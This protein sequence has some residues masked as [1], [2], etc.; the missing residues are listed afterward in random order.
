MHHGAGTDDVLDLKRIAGVVK[1]TGAD[2]IGLQEVDRQE[3]DRHWSSR[4]DFAD[5]AQWLA[6]RLHMHVVYGANLDLDPEQAGDPRRQY[7]T[8][9]L[10]RFPVLG[11]CAVRGASGVRV[12]GPAEHDGYRLRR[13]D[14]R[15][16]G[17]R[18]AADRRG[19]SRGGRGAADAGAGPGAPYGAQG[20]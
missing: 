19:R 9:I 16:R 17:R 10:S 13:C 1:D 2:V 6:D 5:Q 11:R 14:G 7:G 20:A 18:G 4:S 15:G 8:A 3:V 12:R